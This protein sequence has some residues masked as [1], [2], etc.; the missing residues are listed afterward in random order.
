MMTNIMEIENKKVSV[1]ASTG[2]AAANLS[3]A[4]TIHKL[5]G[6]SNRIYKIWQYYFSASLYLDFLQNISHKIPLKTIRKWRF[7][8]IPRYTI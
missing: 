2:I 7:K 5:T 1:S 6:T 3:R 8:F 4:T